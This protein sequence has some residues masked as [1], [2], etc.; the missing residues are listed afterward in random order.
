MMEGSGRRLHGAEENPWSRPTPSTLYPADPT[1]LGDGTLET[2]YGSPMNPDITI[3]Q[4][5]EVIVIDSIKAS[6]LC[7]TNKAN[8]ADW[9]T[10]IEITRAVEYLSTL[11]LSSTMARNVDV[12]AIESDSKP[13]LYSSH[14]NALM[15]QKITIG[16]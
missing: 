12:V 6:V 7:G 9:I 11:H 1:F 5:C 8:G 4:K 3:Q 14:F 13:E 2:V 16:L 10:G 15:N